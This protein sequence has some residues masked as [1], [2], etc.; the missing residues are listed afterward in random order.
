MSPPSGIAVCRI[1][2]ASPRSSGANQCMTARPL[3]ELTLAPAAP[4]SASRTTSDRERLRV[5]RAARKPRTPQAERENDALAEA[6]GGDSP[7]E[8]R[9]ESRRS[10]PPPSSSADLPEREAV[11]RPAAPAR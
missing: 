10:R 6:I 5:R 9:Q 7:G 1:P 4:A 11:L 2:S 3:A 8:Q